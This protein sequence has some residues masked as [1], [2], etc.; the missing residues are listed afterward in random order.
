MIG[1]GRRALDRR[2][3]TEGGP[4]VNQGQAPVL[5][6]RPGVPAALRWVS[7][8]ALTLLAALCLLPFAWMVVTSLKP[9]AEV[10]TNPPR[11]L[12]SL[13]AWWNYPR[14]FTFYPFG[15]FLVNTLFVAV[16]STLLQTTISVLAAYA[17]ARLRFPGRNVLFVAYLGTL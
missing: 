14:A 12:P 16:A 6:R 9:E 13:L 11:W 3:T 7:Y 17:F 1:A 4:L 2:P 8:I 15:R 5:S 10:M